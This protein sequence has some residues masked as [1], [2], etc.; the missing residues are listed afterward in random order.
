MKKVYPDSQWFVVLDEHGEDVMKFDGQS[1][2][3]V[4]DGWR[5]EEVASREE[6]SKRDSDFE[7]WDEVEQS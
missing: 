5:V 7:R 3:K 2:V 1:Y 4:P 6:L